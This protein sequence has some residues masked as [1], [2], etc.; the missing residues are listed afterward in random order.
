MVC[1][2]GMSAELGNRTFGRPDREI[3]IG[4]EYYKEKDYSE[5]TSKVIDKEVR[6]I[7]DKCYDRA[8]DLII[9]NK[10]KLEKLAKALL[11]KE[12]LDSSEVDKL[13]EMMGPIKKIK[14]PAETPY[15][16]KKETENG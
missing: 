8:K 14:K 16:L 7:I 4:G 12:T 6:K 9:K 2:Y 11:E 5:E 13:F 1:E 3:F 15:I 10:A